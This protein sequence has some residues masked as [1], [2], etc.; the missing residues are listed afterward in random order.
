MDNHQLPINALY[1]PEGAITFLKYKEV[2]QTEELQNKVSSLE[3][4]V[5]EMK[6]MIEELMKQK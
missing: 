3:S 1:T 4:Q 5:E 2:E 6:K